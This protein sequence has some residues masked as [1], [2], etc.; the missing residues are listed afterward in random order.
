MPSPPTRTERPE[1]QRLVLRRWRV[2]DLAPFA[3]LNADP[4]GARFLPSTLTRA[5]SDAMERRS[6]SRF[7]GF[8][9]L[10]EV[11]AALPCAPGVEIGWRL[12][13]DAGGNGYATEAATTVLAAAF[14]TLGLEEV[15]SFTARGNE[16]SIA[17]MRRIGMVAD[18]AGD[19]AHASLPTD[20][21]LSLHVLYRAQRVTG[22]AAG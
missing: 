3:R 11:P 14:E 10:Q 19:F 5:Q 20:P 22:A 13:P 15:V 9:G 2:T 8:V 16:P 1:T 4:I 17:V 6:D 21:P 18:A 12:A 7:L